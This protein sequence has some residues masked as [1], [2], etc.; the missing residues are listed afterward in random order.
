MSARMT[1][2]W[3]C[4]VHG[5]DDKQPAVYD[6]LS[7]ESS[8]QLLSVARNSEATI[9]YELSRSFMD[10]APV[11]CARR[12]TVYLHSTATMLS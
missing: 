5:V 6:I 3:P 10:L 8:M 2:L 12:V 7:S 4:A 11:K 1:S 9:F